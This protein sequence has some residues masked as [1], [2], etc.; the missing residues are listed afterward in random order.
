M[1]IKLQ[2]ACNLSKEYRKEGKKVGLITGCFDILHIGHIKFFKEAK[3]KVDIL[4]I[5]LEN[6]KS[7]ELSKGVG[8]PI[9]TF[10]D[11]AEQLNELK[12][13]DYIFRVDD[14]YDFASKEAIL[15]H[16]EI[17]RKLQPTFL[18]TVTVKDK[19]VFRK[20]KI[21]E[22]L[23][24]EFLQIDAMNMSSTSEVLKKVLKTE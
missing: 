12:S 23:G 24:I 19:Y 16:T 21:A 9:N 20:K 7:I 17:W 3:N 15:I 10:V 14:I 6:D 1:I 8:R 11:R 18:L 13:I 4:F 22:E 5:G 2:K